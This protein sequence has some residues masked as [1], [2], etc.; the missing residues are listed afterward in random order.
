M[1]G[2]IDYCSH[3]RAK[4]ETDSEKD[5]YKHKV[6]A[7]LVKTMENLC[8]CVDINSLKMTNL[9]KFIYYQ[10][11]LSFDGAHK[12]YSNYSRYTIK[13]NLLKMK[14][15]IYL[16]F[17]F[18][19][20]SNL[21]IYDTYYNKLQNYYGENGILFSYM[22]TDSFILNMKTRNNIEDLEKSQLKLRNI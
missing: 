20:L 16:G 6:V 8:S 21:L 11:K 2:Y 10:S 15:P 13:T 12:S 4:A 14:K 7:Y 5:F 3:K 22:D 18:L 9:I 19:E 1:K 17:C